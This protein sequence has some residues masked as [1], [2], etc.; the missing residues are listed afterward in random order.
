MVKVLN[1]KTWINLSI[2]KNRKESALNKK[3]IKLINL[4]IKI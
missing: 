2:N 1:I 4:K 3:L